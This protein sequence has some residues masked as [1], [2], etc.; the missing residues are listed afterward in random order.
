MFLSQPQEKDS[1]FSIVKVV[2]INFPLSLIA[3]Y[4]GMFI[5]FG[6]YSSFA[7]IHKGVL[8]ELKFRLRNGQRDLLGNRGYQGYSLINWATLAF[9]SCLTHLA[10]AVLEMDIQNE[11][12]AEEIRRKESG[13]HCEK[14]RE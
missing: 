7:K 5:N 9:M 4:L 2:V 6:I 10:Q 8:V 14:E 12:K 3:F 13:V 11:W 1:R